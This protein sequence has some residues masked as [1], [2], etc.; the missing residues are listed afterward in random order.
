M[1]FAVLFQSRWVEVPSWIG[2]RL[3]NVIAKGAT[4]KY[5]RKVPTGKFSKRGRPKFRYFYKVTGAGGI[6]NDHEIVQHAAFKLANAG[7]AGHFHVQEEHDDNTV[8]VKHDESGTVSRM[9]RSALRQMLHDEHA[10]ALKQAGVDHEESRAKQLAR[11]LADLKEA[12]ESGTPGHVAALKKQA[13]ALG[14]TEDDLLSPAEMDQRKKA[15]EE[16]ARKR[17]KAE[18]QKPEPEPEPEDDDDSEDDSEDDEEADD[19]SDESAD[20]AEDDDDAEP[21]EKKPRKSRKTGEHQ[22][23]GEHVSGARRDLF[24]AT[25]EE[26]MALSPEERSEL[27]KRD[28]L[29]K[30]ISAKEARERGWSAGSHELYKELIKLIDKEPKFGRSHI[31][32]WMKNFPEDHHDLVHANRI[33]KFEVDQA[34]KRYCDGLVMFQKLFDAAGGD[35]GKTIESLAETAIQFVGIERGEWFNWRI[36]EYVQMHTSPEMATGFEVKLPR[37]NAGRKAHIFDIHPARTETGASLLQLGR[38]FSDTM[39]SLARMRYS[40]GDIQYKWDLSVDDDITLAWKHDRQKT[41]YNPNTKLWDPKD[42]HWAAIKQA[43]EVDRFAGWQEPE[44][45]EPKGEKKDDG[46]E[47]V[48]PWTKQFYQHRLDGDPVRTGGR[49]LAKADAKAMSEEFGLHN[50]D[51]GNWVEQEARSKHLHWTHTA[52]RDLEDVI[53]IPPGSVALGSLA[54]SGKRNKLAIAIGARGKGKALAHYEALAKDA[55]TGQIVPTINLTKSGGGGTLAHEWGHFLDNLLGSALSPD[56]GSVR[57]ATEKG[58]SGAQFPGLSA[59]LEDAKR[60]IFISNYA[61]DG[62]ALGKKYWGSK[63]ELWARAFESYIEDKMPTKSMRNDYLVYG[64]KKTYQTG[65]FIEPHPRVVAHAISVHPEYAQLRDWM[66]RA[67]KEA[68]ASKPGDPMRVAYQA[69]YERAQV[70]RKEITEKL[71]RTAQVYPQGEER[72]KISKA[73]D[74]LFEVIA[75]HNVITKAMGLVSLLSR[76]RTGTRSGSP[77]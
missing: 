66:Q 56:D 30:P 52:L 29:L 2:C 55:K 13:L 18:K 54:R 25:T 43:I 23:V 62:A 50:V 34:H 12:H 11:T 67:V 16:S 31:P 35:L 42:P 5:L 4:H 1:N 17:K 77:A 57:W 33:V 9:K 75:K 72:T 63:V 36:K 19:D 10:D 73:F 71:S 59:A 41:K 37:G 76:P 60:A 40:P 22:E 44:K 46:K 24:A 28:K 48:E 39:Y 65:K 51:F 6:G 74:A 14:A 7:K 64:T 45:K 21:G 53:G 49:A 27:V 15:A 61:E 68:N 3:E 20:D 69:K 58:I 38:R 8:T 32:S 26:V 70:I 47:K